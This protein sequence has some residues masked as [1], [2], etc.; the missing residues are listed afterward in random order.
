M[1]E[2]VRARRWWRYSAARED[3]RR[4]RLRT[5][6]RTSGSFRAASGDSSQSSMTSP[7]V[8]PGAPAHILLQ[9]WLRRT[10]ADEAHGDASIPVVVAALAPS[11]GSRRYS[12]SEIQ[13]PTYEPVVGRPARRAFYLEPRLCRA[14]AALFVVCFIGLIYSGKSRSGACESWDGATPSASASSMGRGTTGRGPTPWSRRRRRRSCACRTTPSGSL[15]QNRRARRCTSTTSSRG[16]SRARTAARRKK[17]AASVCSLFVLTKFV[18]VRCLF[19]SSSGSLGLGTR[20]HILNKFRLPS[21][22]VGR[23]VYS[24]LPPRYARAWEA[25]ARVRARFLN[26]PSCPQSWNLATGPRGGARLSGGV[27]SVTM[28]GHTQNA[29]AANGTALM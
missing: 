5:F 4:P 13:A 22:G 3:G 23:V 12:A 27:T 21:L 9:D 19:Y 29:W 20:T 18:C 16:R 26:L 10:A 25:E 14:P 7:K 11:V 8:G 24:R 2:S 15:I 1:P 28:T 6:A 17:R